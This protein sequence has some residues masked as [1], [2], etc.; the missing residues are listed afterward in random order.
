M[1]VVL[2]PGRPNRFPLTGSDPICGVK[3]GRASLYIG[4]NSI[5]TNTNRAT[6]ITDGLS[7]VRYI[8][9]IEQSMLAKHELKMLG[10]GDE[11]IDTGLMQVQSHIH[12]EGKIC[13]AAIMAELRDVGPFQLPFPTAIIHASQP[14]DGSTSGGGGGSRLSPR[15]Y[16]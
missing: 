4:Y 1:M 14:W 7:M 15:L 12:S 9:S 16:P 6:R 5:M 8:P 3:E 2:R 10:L 11:E 13:I